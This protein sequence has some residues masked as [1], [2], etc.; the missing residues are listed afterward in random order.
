VQHRAGELV[1]DPQPGGR[2]AVAEADLL[3]GVDLP[4]LVGCGR[5]PRRGLRTPPRR[6]RAEAGP[7]EP[8]LEGTHA[9][10]RP[11]PLIL[12]VDPDQTGPPTRV[13]ATEHRRGSEGGVV[14]R[15]GRVGEAAITRDEAPLTPL[16]TPPDEVSHRARG[17]AEGLTQL[18][19]RSPLYMTT[20]DGLS[21]RQGDGGGHGGILEERRRGP[22]S[23]PL[24]CAR[25]VA[26]A[27]V[28]CAITGRT[29]LRVTLGPP[30]AQPVSRFQMRIAKVKPNPRQVTPM[31]VWP[32]IVSWLD[33]TELSPK[34]RPARIRPRLT[35]QGRRG[36]GHR[37]LLTV[38]RGLVIGRRRPA[39]LPSRSSM[40]RGP[41]PVGAPALGPGWIGRRLARPGRFAE[42]QVELAFCWLDSPARGHPTRCNRQVARCPQSVIGVPRLPS[43]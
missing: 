32:Q 30:L 7:A 8:L 43:A 9:G 18:R 10:Q 24:Q 19:D 23:G 36:R 13:F 5:P 31:R 1:G 26:P 4:D 11:D 29:S 33:V 21:D 2:G 34:T 16:A 15:R 38:G 20:S 35:A 37:R 6:R 12:Q 14:R 39:P 22:R 42:R 3:G 28:L 40:R 27:K 25:V 41:D 17:D